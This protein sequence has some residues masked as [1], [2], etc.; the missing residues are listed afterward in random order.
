MT[1]EVLQLYIDLCEECQ[2]KK[3][4][5]RKT[6]AGGKPCATN[7]S[8]VRGDVQLIDM[9]ERRDE[10]YQYILRYQDLTTGFV[11]LRPLRTSRAEEVANHLTD[12]FCTFGSPY[13]LQ[14]DMGREFTERT[15]AEVRNLWA[16]CVLVH[17]VPPPN[18]TPPHSEAKKKV[19]SLVEEWMRANDTNSWAYGL[20]FVQW[21]T[22]NMRHGDVK[23]TPHF[24]MF[25]EEPRL[26]VSSISLIGEDKVMGLK[27]EEQLKEILGSST[28]IASQPSQSPLPIQAPLQ[29]EISTTA[30]E[31]NQSAEKFKSSSYRGGRVEENRSSTT[32]SSTTPP[33]EDSDSNPISNKEDSMLNTPTQEVSVPFP[34]RKSSAT[35]TLM[36][37]VFR[38]EDM[39]LDVDITGNNSAYVKVESISPLSSVDDIFSSPGYGPQASVNPP[40]EILSGAP[41][42]LFETTT[43]SVCNFACNGN[44]R[45]SVCDRC[46]HEVPPCSKLLNP[47]ALQSI[48]CI[49]CEMK[50]EMDAYQQ[51]E[52]LLPTE[53]HGGS[54]QV[55][56]DALGSPTKKIRMSFVHPHP[57]E[58]ERMNFH[59]SAELGMVKQYE[60]QRFSQFAAF[61]SGPSESV[62]M[63]TY[64]ENAEVGM[65]Q[66]ST[67]HTYVQTGG[68]HHPYIRTHGQNSSYTS[69]STNMGEKFLQ[70]P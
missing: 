37:I 42:L 50:Q 41:S 34:G 47:P 1:K 57:P 46:C 25:C 18:T 35:E 52:P 63:E 30:G 45:C 55:V 15:V 66:E 69:T 19:A 48:L 8:K 39:K 31:A 27:C 44:F 24:A 36:D 17:G 32:S 12:I 62:T 29:A 10:D 70:F 54:G 7:A 14:S 67:D 49:M 4:R 21:Q 65:R 20:R 13:V 22:N 40:E 59:Q 56:S 11:W 53:G 3:T 16:A 64:R 51:S 33:N 38:E 9:R 26:G 68:G 60:S 28:S 58:L 61:H 6:F 5:S 23:R 2:E 43:C